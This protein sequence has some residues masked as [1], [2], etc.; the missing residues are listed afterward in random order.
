MLDAEHEHGNQ[1]T[2]RSCP[3]CRSRAMRPAVTITSR[4]LHRGAGFKNRAPALQGCSTKGSRAAGGS[5]GG[6]GD[7]RGDPCGRRHLTSRIHAHHPCTPPTRRL[8]RP[9]LL[10]QRYPTRV[11]A[12]NRPRSQVP[13]FEQICSSAGRAVQGTEAMD[14]AEFRSARDALI[15]D[16]VQ[17]RRD[18][19]CP[20]SGHES[21]SQS[22]QEAGKLPAH[23]CESAAA[24]EQAHDWAA[25][26]FQR[27]DD[28]F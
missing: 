23:L 20:Q 4:E 13:R 18:R 6:N 15:T 2:R 7:L 16:I 8:S 27:L 3:W 25:I 14:D 17:V 12:P 28:V 19:A 22:L 1:P 24:M 10:R 5:P 9:V 11:R 21:R 26:Q